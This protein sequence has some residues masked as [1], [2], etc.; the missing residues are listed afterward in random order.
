MRLLILLLLVALPA[1]AQEVVTAL[2]PGQTQVDPDE[3][4]RI[5][6]EILDARSQ[7]AVVGAVIALY[8]PRRITGRVWPEPWLPDIPAQDEAPVATVR[9]A[10]EGQF[11]FDGLA[12]GLYRIAPL[13]DASAQ[14]TTVEVILTR[15]RPREFVALRTNLGG[16]VDGRVVG[17][18]GAPVPGMFVYVA[19]LDDGSGGNALAGRSPSTRTVSGDDGTFSLGDVP[20]GSLQIQA[21]RQDFGFSPLLALTIGVAE[22]VKGLEFVVAD[23]RDR[24][25]RGRAERGGL[26]VV[27]DFDPT[28]VRVRSL[29]PGL[30][31]EAAGLLAGDRI[32]ALDGAST[33]WMIRHEFFNRARGAVG[34]PLV[35]TVSRGAQPPFDLTV[36]RAEMPER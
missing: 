15:E 7:L 6:G 33:R 10:S 25:E 26:G 23:E 31:A 35:L 29:L 30:P 28:G 34:A 3:S 13:L 16:Q 2:A 4:G 21:G 27:V 22:D 1:R 32:L 14:V 9:A 18:D 24:I 8:H 12:P 20:P 5:S 19:G 11:L 17:G 36:A